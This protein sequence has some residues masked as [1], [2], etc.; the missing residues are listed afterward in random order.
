MAT[1][2]A[3]IEAALKAATPGPW[4][5][6]IDDWDCAVV[7]P[8][9]GPGVVYICKDIHQGKDEGE[10]DAYLIANAPTWIAELIGRVKAAEAEV[11][12][13][14]AEI[15]AIRASA[16][17]NKFRCCEC[18]PSDHHGPDLVDVHEIPC[19]IHQDPWL[20]RATAAE[21]AIARV[22]KVADDLEATDYRA[23]SVVILE[24]LEGNDVAS[25]D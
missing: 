13:S 1:D 8:D 20:N 15:N 5:T 10:S 14:F 19:T 16:Q 11:E 3:V 18:C 12:R 6:D 24:A 9:P 2:L 7:R 21:A 23:L 17:P 4:E 22:R 25:D